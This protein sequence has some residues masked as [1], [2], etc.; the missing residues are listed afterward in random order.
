MHAA[1]EPIPRRWRPSRFVAAS[2]ACHGAAVMGTLAVPGQWRLGLG[3]LALNHALILSQVLQPRSQ[4]LG[5]SWTRL[6][7]PIG[8][9]VAI[10]LDDGPDPQVTPRVL[11]QL[12]AHRVRA[13][14][15]CIGKRVRQHPALTR[16]IV[17]A[18]HLVENHTEHHWHTFSLL[19]PE[20]IRRE[21][22]QAQVSIAE[23][24]G[25][26]PCFFRAPAGLRNPFLDP[27]LARTGLTLASW[28]RRGFDTVNGDAERVLQSLVRGLDARDILLLHDG[29]AARSPSG[30]P[31]VLEVLPR[32]MEALR[33]DGL[34]PV[35]LADALE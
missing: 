7:E 28:T 33:V 23:V 14:F 29:H 12:A 34:T 6:P 30:T 19:G 10:T 17:A 21:I 2:M 4:A 3:A 26:L 15:F 18:G 8:R 31:V 1:S 20:G 13:T 27:L 16:E 9:A 35:R 5:P 24:T 11:E 25:R 22:E 32:L